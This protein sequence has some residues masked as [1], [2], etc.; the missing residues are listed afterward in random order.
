ASASCWRPC[1]WCR[2]GRG[3]LTPY[4]RFGGG[5][6]VDGFVGGLILAA[7]LAALFIAHPLAALI[8]P[9]YVLAYAIIGFA[10]VS[11]ARFLRNH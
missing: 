7:L 8:V 11:V 4:G 2:I 5:L 9:L 10:L 1:P 6:Y 3:C